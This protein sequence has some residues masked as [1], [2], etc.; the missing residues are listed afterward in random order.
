[1]TAKELQ[2]KLI[3]EGWVFTEGSRHT[4]VSHPNKPG[5]KF[6]LHRHTGDIPAGTLNKILQITGLK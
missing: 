2:K 3:V 4:Q 6:S 5:V 1:M